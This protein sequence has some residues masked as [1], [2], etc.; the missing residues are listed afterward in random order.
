MTP[1]GLAGTMV[2]VMVAAV[3]IAGLWLALGG[4]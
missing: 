4:L 2:V 1:K 3:L